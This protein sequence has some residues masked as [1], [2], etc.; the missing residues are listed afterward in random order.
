MLRP[1]PDS[2]ESPETPTT[3]GQ[4]TAMKIHH[5]TTMTITTA[6]VTLCLGCSEKKASSG[7][8]RNVILICLDTVRSDHLGAYGYEKHETTPGLDA[9]A[10]RSILF[11]DASSNAGWTKPSV[12]S[13]MTGLY[14]VQHGV[15]E[16]HSRDSEGEH[17][18]VLPSSALTI[19]EV[20]QS[21]GYSTAAFVRNAQIREGQGIEQGFD[22][23]MDEAGD[24]KDIRWRALDWLD[25]RDEEPPFFLYLHLLDA[26]WPYPVPAEYGALFSDLEAVSFFRTDEWKELRDRI[27]DGD[28]VLSDAQR[29]TLIALYDGALRFI[30][31][32]LMLLMQGLEQRGLAEDTVIC[33]I[34]DHGEE[35]LEHGKIGHGHGLHEELLQVPWILH[36]PGREASV[37]ETPVSL[38]DL[39]PTLLH[40][41]DLSVKIECEGIDR[42]A[43]PML[44]RENFAEHKAG[45]KYEQSVRRG[46]LK[47]IRHMQSTGTP[48]VTVE[49][50]TVGELAA[51]GARFSLELHPRPAA[52]PL[53]AS[54]KV[55]GTSDD[56]I[57]LKGMVEDITD[58]GIVLGGI[59]VPLLKDVVLYGN[60]KD[61]QGV[62]RGLAVGVGVKIKIRKT[63]EGFVGYRVKLYAQE[64]EVELELRGIPEGVERVETGSVL[65]FGFV[66]VATDAKTVVEVGGARDHS[67]TREELRAFLFAGGASWKP[68]A[69]LSELYSLEHEGAEEEAF[70][71]PSEAAV[72]SGLLDAFGMRLSKSPLWTAQDRSALSP[73][74]IHDLSAIGYAGGDD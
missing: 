13:Y 25:Q 45:R 59:H 31:D 68:F 15:Y 72:L 23:Y 55:R 63:A 73:K 26:H 46:Y 22:S 64:G 18:D 47:L 24:A 56:P 61:S 8:H 37:V 51:R 11:R 40:A 16:G 2:T 70:D 71:A 49:P 35:F 5:W 69:H 74:D 21:A 43:S 48:G 57:E 66:R 10:K 32:Q 36:V 7:E 53:T 65:D 20:F 39:F 52:D 27:N 3:S 17:S 62:E 6:M 1:E 19:A 29:D 34:S 38:V 41:A 9:L 33:I 28:L 14:P 4:A 42:L 67:L 44:W 12:P 60:T 30:D 50:P 54:V 58:D